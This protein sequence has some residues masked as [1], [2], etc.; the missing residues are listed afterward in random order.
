MIGSKTFG[1]S[2]LLQASSAPV[3]VASCLLDTIGDAALLQFA[4]YT[5]LW[6]SELVVTQLTSCISVTFQPTENGKENAEIRKYYISNLLFDLVGKNAGKWPCNTGIS[7]VIKIT[8]LIVRL[9]A[10]ATI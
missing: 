7:L 1:T 2:V 9:Q 4:R 3:V 10:R 8:P 5:I 6:H